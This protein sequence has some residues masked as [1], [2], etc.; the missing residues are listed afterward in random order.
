M[1]KKAVTGRSVT[2]TDKKTYAFKE[3]INI[4]VT[5]KNTGAVEGEEVVQLYVRDLVASVTLPL[6]ELKR[7]SKIKL[8]P[9]ESKKVTFTLTSDDLAFYTKDMSFK[10]EAGEFKLFV[11][12]NSVEL[13]ETNFTLK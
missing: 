2:V 8:K 12:T 3:K 1:L 13:L 11:G 6:K 7:F 5:V 10:A 9:D 4:S